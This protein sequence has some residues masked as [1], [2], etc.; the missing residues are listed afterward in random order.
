M[1]HLYLVLFFVFSTVVAFGQDA[2][3]SS[4]I[5]GLKLYPNPVTSGKI[6]ISTKKNAPKKILIFDV[7]GNKALETKLIGKELNLSNLDAGVYVIRVFEKDKV[8]T[9]KLI[10][11]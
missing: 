2:K 6:Y 8:A 5:E 3:N 11:K 4:D 9:R 7:L 10:I 1:K